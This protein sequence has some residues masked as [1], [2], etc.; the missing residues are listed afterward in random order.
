MERTILILITVFL[1]KACCVENTANCHKIITVVNNTDK[2]IYVI[3][4]YCY[5]N[6][7][8]YRN[9]YSLSPL[10][11]GY[12]KILAHESSQGHNN[13]ETALPSFGTCYE[14]IYSSQIESDAMMIYI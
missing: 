14:A 13:S 5:P 6:T 4:D 12:S 1:L 2:A 11:S 3:S 10:N 7:D 8:A 9:G